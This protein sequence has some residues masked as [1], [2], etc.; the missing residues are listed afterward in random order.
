MSNRIMGFPLAPFLL[1]ILTLSLGC[2]SKHEDK[3]VAVDRCYFMGFTPF[4]W[5]FYLEA[6]AGT[7]RSSTEWGD[8]V[9][10]HLEQGVPWTEAAEEK[11]FHPKMME[12]WNNRKKTAE[13]KKLFLSL[14]PLNEARNSMDLY[15]G[16]KEDM[17]LPETFQNKSFNDPIIKQAY[18]NYCLRAVEFFQPDYLAIGIEINELFHNAP[19]QWS[20]FRELYLDTYAELKKKFPTLP[21]LAT[22]SLHN[23]T[24]PGWQDRVEQQK[25]IHDLLAHADLMGISYYPFMA[26]QLERPQSTLDWLRNFTDKPIAI[27]E[28]GFPAEII[29]LKTFNVT[30]S[31][32]PEKQKTYYQ[33]ILERAN[34]D[35]YRFVISFLIRDYD[36]LW[37]KIKNSSPEAFVVWRDCGMVDEQGISR[38]AFDVWKDYYS[39]PIIDRAN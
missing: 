37:E 28:T 29:S 5:D 21:V 13:G 35:E 36:A 2:S 38:P 15:R 10:H 23:L 11:P 34:R 27:T 7:N 3:I 16:E 24:N 9:S 18:L 12:D 14:T 8:I 22:F 30:I 4:P 17:P 25:E 39:L 6:V 31:G 20:S 32:D 33:T 26:G 1:V 19:N